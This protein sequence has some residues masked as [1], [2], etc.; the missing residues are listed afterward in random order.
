[1]TDIGS[2]NG[3]RATTT[4]HTGLQ[5]LRKRRIALL[6]ER[7]ITHNELHLADEVFAEDFHWPQFDLH[8]PDGVRTWV[9]DFRAAFPDVLDTVQEQ[10]A[11]G[12]VVITRV[13]VIGTQSGEFRGLPPSGRRAD[14]T[15]VGIDRFRGDKVVERTALFDFVDLMRQLGHTRLDLPGVA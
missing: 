7:I 3:A 9:T 1:M 11:E 4:D 15:A 2:S 6:F 10:V 8:G 5:E 13:R 12:D 14:F